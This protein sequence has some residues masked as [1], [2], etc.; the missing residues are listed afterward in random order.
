MKTNSRKENL[1][2]K[3]FKLYTEEGLS[4]EKIA[5]REQLTQQTVYAFINGKKELLKRNQKTPILVEKILGRKTV[6]YLNE[7]EYGTPSLVYRMKDLTESEK[8]LVK[9]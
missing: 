8:K 2:T 1:K 6:E 7:M 3:V 9:W 5:K 4:V